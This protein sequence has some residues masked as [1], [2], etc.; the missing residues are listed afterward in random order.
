MKPANKAVLAGAILLVLL[1]IGFFFLDTSP[2]ARIY[3]QYVHLPG[4][5]PLAAVTV[6]EFIDFQCP[7]CKEMFP[8]MQRLY[9]ELPEVNFV[10]RHI[11]ATK[12]HPDAWEAAIA[13]EC[14]REQD[15]YWEYAAILFNNQNALKPVQLRA[16]A[17]QSGMD[18]IRFDVCAASMEKHELIKQHI[19][20]ALLADVQ[21]TPTYFIN[22][23]K[24]QGVQDYM[25][26]KQLLEA[27]IRVSN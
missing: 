15:K 16:Y 3:D 19:D 1:L 14:A 11:P 25:A 4:S 8:I 22:G 26:F 2:S 20:E 17:Q 5:N 23:K 21:G 27:M 24:V 13:A 12:L 7:Y 9:D 10:Q 6:V 18:I